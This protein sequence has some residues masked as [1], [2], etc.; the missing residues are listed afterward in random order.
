MEFP[1][2][3]KPKKTII[4]TNVTYV[5]S[6]I[7]GRVA[8]M[9]KTR[10]L[11]T[12]LCTVL[13]SSTFAVASVQAIPLPFPIGASSGI[14]VS[15]HQHPNGSSINWQDVK[16]HGQSF[17]F[18]KATEGLGWTND[19]YA[20]D[21]TQ[22]AAQGLKVGSYHYARPGAD[23]RQQAR[24]YAKVIF[25]TPNHSLPPV[26]DLEVAEGK[27]PQEL[28]NWTRDFVQELEKQTGR[29]PMIYTYRYFWIEQMA[30]TTEF[31]QYPLW[32]AAYQAQVPGTVGGWDQIDFWQ[33]S[34]SGRIN[35][36]VGDVDMNLFNGDD[37][38]LA[39]FAAGN[40]HAAGNK[41]ASIN[42][43]ELADLGKSAGGVVAVILA[44]SAGAA[45]APQL[46]QAAE[47]A[48][49]SS[50]GAQD[51]TA[52]V[53]ALAKAGKLPVDQLNK[54]ASGNYTVGDLIIL[55]DNAAHLAGIDVGQSSQAAMRA[56]GLNIDANQ[57][58]RV[59]RGLA[60]R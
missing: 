3:L 5:T 43:P 42:L 2:V 22:A 52:V 23:A 14:D 11:K 9:M 26:L 37:G 12:A 21:I 50:E 40:L 30:N 8:I 46:I 20:S 34:S 7:I 31:S 29:V 56:D 39:A 54:M 41:F 24:H 38:E 4:V 17:A 44:L 35:G 36:I 57:V 19:F 6:G 28:V 15:G 45:A 18:V 10:R 53:Q 51:L 1:S 49:L 59:I 47:A 16:S 58:A 32:L 48:G 33:R 13:A 25:H 60:A 27:T 55:L